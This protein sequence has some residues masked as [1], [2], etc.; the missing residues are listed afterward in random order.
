MAYMF[1]HLVQD[2]ICYLKNTACTSIL[3]QNRPLVLFDGAASY[4]HNKQQPPQQLNARLGIYIKYID[5]DAAYKHRNGI[6]QF[7]SQKCFTY[8][9]DAA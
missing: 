5:T 9:F 3:H 7:C 4:L 1:D 2:K 6:N 8:F